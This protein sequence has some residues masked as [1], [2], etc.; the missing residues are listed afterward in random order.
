MSWDDI[1]KKSGGDSENKIDF[2]SFPEGTTQIRVIGKEPYSFWNHW[3]TKQNMGTTCPGKGCPI[4]AV[5]A[6]Q[7]ANKEKQTYS[8]TRRHAIL[9]WNYSTQKYEIMAQGQNFFTDLRA[10]HKDIGDVTTYDIKVK[11]TGTDM[12][13]TKYTLMPMQPTEFAVVEEPPAVE[14]TEILKPI[15]HDKLILLMEGKSKEEVFGNQEV[16]E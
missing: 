7:K 2:T 15:D 10:L 8:S 9:I 13:N 4:C 11:R 6:A 16:A 1:D 14:M 12:N 5:I 3:L